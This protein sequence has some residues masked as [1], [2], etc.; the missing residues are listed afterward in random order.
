MKR[1]DRP[2]CVC[3]Q[4]GRLKDMGERA[5]P[6][7]VITV[8]LRPSTCG[9]GSSQD[10]R[11]EQGGGVGAVQSGKVREGGA[12]PLPTH[13]SERQAVEGHVHEAVVPTEAPAAGPGQ[14]L[15][16]HLGRSSD[17]ARWLGSKKSGPRGSPQVP[18]ALPSPL[19]TLEGFR[20]TMGVEGVGETGGGHGLTAAC[21]RAP[22][23]G[24]VS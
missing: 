23:S 6:W 13:S 4:T 21:H 16:D 10:C 19:S 11:G 14:H 24:R 20:F 8:C 18:R 22:D 17:E 1:M 7:T 2:L 5:A 3:R 12:L 9:K 15:L